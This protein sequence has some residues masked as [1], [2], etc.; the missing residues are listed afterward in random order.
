MK[1][2]ASVSPILITFFVGTN[3][4]KSGFKAVSNFRLAA[5]KSVYAM[6]KYIFNFPF[7]FTLAIMQF[8]AKRR[9]L[10]A[11]RDTRYRGLASRIKDKGTF[12]DSGIGHRVTGDRRQQT[13]DRTFNVSFCGLLVFLAR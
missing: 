3:S 5:N 9:Q 11:I 12:R 7:I 8:D 13:G 6:H 4:T 2:L 1:T 10:I